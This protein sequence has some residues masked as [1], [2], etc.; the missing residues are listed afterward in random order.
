VRSVLLTAKPFLFKEGLG[1]PVR[2]LKLSAEIE[3]MR[4]TKKAATAVIDEIYPPPVCVLSPGSDDGDLKNQDRAVTEDGGPKKRFAIVCDGLTQSPYSAEAAEYV[5]SNVAL[6]HAEGGV[7][8]IVS[9][10]NEKRNRLKDSPVN[11]DHIE[12]QVL[13]SMFAD[14]LR[15]K[16]ELSYQT[17][18]ISTCLEIDE[19]VPG[20]LHLRICGC[21][22]SGLFVFTNDGKLLYNNFDLN[23]EEDGF[24]HLSP[25]TKA[26]PDNCDEASIISHSR[27]FPYGIHL[28][29]C[30]DG[31]YDCFDNFSGIF[32]WLMQNRKCMVQSSCEEELMTQLHFSLSSKKG[33]DD[34]SFIWLL[35]ADNL[36]MER[37][38]NRFITFCENSYLL[39]L[40]LGF[41]R[42][43]GSIR[44]KE[45]EV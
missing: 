21:G 30:S 28:L 39:G 29:L 24:E 9:G 31:F 4:A 3:Y 6:L 10:L 34:I 38:K 40:L 35:P 7:Q 36:R 12:S 5:S 44:V 32:S 18:F 16:R 43:L 20:Q 37:K 8:Q 26:L 2:A 23:D 19:N 41:L 13:K 42:W 15:E 1:A 14:I 27:L 25:I 22:D 11:L 17:T 45:S 33:D